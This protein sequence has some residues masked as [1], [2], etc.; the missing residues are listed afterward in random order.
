MARPAKTN[1]K[2]PLEQHPRQDGECKNMIK[3]VAKQYSKT[4]HL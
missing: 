4:Y 2:N 1:Q 3:I